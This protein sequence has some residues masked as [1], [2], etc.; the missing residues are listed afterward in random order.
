[1]TYLLDT[2]ILSKWH[3]I[4]RFP[5]EKLKIWFNKIDIEACFVSVFTI[6]EIQKGIAKRKEGKEKRHLEAWLLGKLIPVLQDRILS[7]DKQ[8][9]II[10]GEL[11]GNGLSAGIS[12]PV[13]DSL[14]AATAI[15]HNL[16]LV[17]ENIR[18]FEKID[19]L[20]LFSP[21]E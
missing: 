18:D 16:I 3:K 2:C 20:N 4:D 1:M 11:T 21:W 19:K 17:T 14:L 8:E 12:L 5:D 13:I 6:G 15:S 10:W 9:A 7:F